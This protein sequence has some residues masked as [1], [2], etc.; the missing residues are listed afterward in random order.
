MILFAYLYFVLVLF[1]YVRYTQIRTA[2]R[3]GKNPMTQT[4][5]FLRDFLGMTILAW[6]GYAL[7]VIT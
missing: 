1:F 5:V 3:I 4:P 7:L 2:N 6:A